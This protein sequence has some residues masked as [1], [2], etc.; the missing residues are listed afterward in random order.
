MHSAQGVTCNTK[1]A[2]DK[3]TYSGKCAKHKGSDAM[4]R[5][6]KFLCL[7]RMPVHGAEVTTSMLCASSRQTGKEV[8]GNNCQEMSSNPSGPALPRVWMQN[9]EQGPRGWGPCPSA[10]FHYSCGWSCQSWTFW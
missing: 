7:C 2:M 3:G 9:A 10:A 8:G 5:L 1:F 6:A 4:P